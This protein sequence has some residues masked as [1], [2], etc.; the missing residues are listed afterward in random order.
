MSTVVYIWIGREGG[1]ELRYLIGQVFDRRNGSKKN[2]EKT[3]I[4][5]IIFNNT[6]NIIIFPLRFV[7]Y[8]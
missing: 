1:G 7:L 3:R 2:F 8:V 6:K 5:A 4:S